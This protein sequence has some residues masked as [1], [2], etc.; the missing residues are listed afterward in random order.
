MTQAFAGCTTRLY[1]TGARSIQAVAV[2]LRSERPQDSPRSK[3]RS[4]TRLTKIRQQHCSTYVDGS[5][6]QHST[7]YTVQHTVHRTV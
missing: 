3:A 4:Q 6:V 7:Q 1:H 5:T 2:H